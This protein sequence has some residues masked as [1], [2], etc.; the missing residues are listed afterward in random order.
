VCL[1]VAAGD[2]LP[3]WLVMVL[4][5]SPDGVRQRGLRALYDAATGEFMVRNAACCVTAKVQWCRAATHIAR[6]PCEQVSSW[7]SAVFPTFL[8]CGVQRQPM[9]RRHSRCMVFTTW[10]PG[11]TAPASAL[12]SMNLEND[13]FASI[14][15]ERAVDLSTLPPQLQAPGPPLAADPT[16]WLPDPASW[17]GNGVRVQIVE[18]NNGRYY[19][20]CTTHGTCLSSSA[21][22]AFNFAMP[23]SAAKR[24]GGRTLTGRW[25]QGMVA[26]APQEQL[27]MPRNAQ[28]M[29]FPFLR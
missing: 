19:R 2:A 5:T 20:V 26:A 13:V 25:Q 11:L 23:L 1:L 15:A 18:D 9:E 10:A 7:C 28:Y 24:S 27:A 22:P 6:L 4:L 21:A 14:D 8:D 12:Q 17:R 16:G 29:C 3:F